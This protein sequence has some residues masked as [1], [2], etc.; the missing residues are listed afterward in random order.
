MTANT[1]A[2]PQPQES[3]APMEPGSSEGSQAI[4]N[5]RGGGCWLQ[6]VGSTGPYLCAS[7]YSL[8]ALMSGA[9]ALFASSV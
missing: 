1:L 8:S 4:E 9:M 3:H 7:Q 6:R 2:Q 5:R